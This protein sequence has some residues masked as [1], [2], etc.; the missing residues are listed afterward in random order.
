M[1][2]VQY[3]MGANKDLIEKASFIV[4]VIIIILT[5]V[6]IDWKG[7]LALIVMTIIWSIPAEKMIHQ[8]YN[9]LGK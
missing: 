3:G 9:K 8:I 4:Q 6:I 1:R 2:L 5:F 7:G